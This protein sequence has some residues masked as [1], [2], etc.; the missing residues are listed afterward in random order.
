[1]LD[2]ETEAAFDRQDMVLIPAGT[3]LMGAKSGVYRKSGK[4]DETP[5]HEVY[6]DAFYMDKYEVTVAQ[7]QKFLAANSDHYKPDHW[8]EQLQH[9]NHP[10]VFVSWD[11]ANAYAKWAGKRLPTEAEWEYAARGGYTGVGFRILGGKPKYKYPWGNKY[12]ESKVNFGKVVGYYGA[13]I[14]GSLEN[15]GSYAPNSYGLYDMAGNVW[16]WCADWYD[17]DYY[18]NFKNTPAHNPKGPASG[19]SRVWRGGSWN[20]HPSFL[21]CAGR[22]YDVPTRRHNN[23]GF[24]CVQD[25]R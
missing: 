11:D 4:Y 16:E 8:D 20:T 18:Q 9:P 1:M 15:V 22:D 5:E 10:V 23:V 17:E 24:R 2:K 7:Y 6:V 13:P 25:V 14:T 21:P 3:F 19:L 12:S